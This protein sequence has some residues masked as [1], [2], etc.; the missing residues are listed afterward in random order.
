MNQEFRSI[1]QKEKILLLILIYIKFPGY[2]KSTIIELANSKS[3]TLELKQFD[4][5]S[6]IFKNWQKIMK[7]YLKVNKIIATKEKILIVLEQMKGKTTG[8]FVE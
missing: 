2:N 5:S 4:G 6:I 3:I 8:I 1:N 7:I